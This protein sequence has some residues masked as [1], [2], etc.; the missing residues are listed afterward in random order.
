LQKLRQ[1]RDE[2]FHRQEILRARNQF[3]TLVRQRAKSVLERLRQADPKGGWKDICGFD[4]RISWS[5]EEFDEWKLSNAGSLALKNGTLNPSDPG[6]TDV[7][8]DLTIAD[9]KDENNTDTFARG[10]CLK[11]RCERHKQ[12]VKIHQQDIQFEENIVQQDLLKC[13]R[14]A[15]AAVERAVLRMWADSG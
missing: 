1:Q 15:Q 12:W 5:D 9:S 13:E 10:T 11:K 2:L 7:G 6:P 8:S 14:E 4:S 3:M